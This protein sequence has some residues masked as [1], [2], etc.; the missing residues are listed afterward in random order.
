MPLHRENNETS[1][2]VRGS[3]TPQLEVEFLGWVW[4]RKSLLAFNMQFSY[5]HKYRVSFQ[6]FAQLNKQSATSASKKIAT[7]LQYRPVKLYPLWTEWL[8]DLIS[9]WG[10]SNMN[11][12]KDFVFS[13]C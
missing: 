10:K 12:E 6:K 5:S 3:W 13:E 4:E 2:S 11:R 7:G 8:T 1:E 9:Y